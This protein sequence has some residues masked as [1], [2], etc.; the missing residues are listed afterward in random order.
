MD[1]VYTYTHICIVILNLYPT[2]VVGHCPCLV[3]ISYVALL[4]IWF[5]LV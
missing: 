2:H 3:V 4:M 1:C 5:S